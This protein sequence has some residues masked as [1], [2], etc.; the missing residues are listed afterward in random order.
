MNQIHPGEVFLDENG[1]VAQLHGIGIARIGDRWWAWG[2]DKHDGSS[3]RAVAC[4]S[5]DDLATW[6][7]EGD[8]LTAASDENGT[9]DLGAA[10][11]VERPKVLQHPDGRF[12]MLLHIDAMDYSDA[13]VGW[14]VADAPQGPYRY[15][16]SRRPLGNQSRDIG[17]YQEGADAYLLS[18]DRANGLHIYRLTDDYL[19]V[20]E[21]VATTLKPG[22]THGYE[23]PT[24]VHVDGLYYQF[25]SDLTGWSTN[26]NRY[27]TAES[28]AGP[29]SPWRLFAPEGSNTF[30]SQV[31]V[32][33]PVETEA[34]LAHVYIGD[35][36]RPD[37]LV[38]SPAVWLPLAVG[39][40]EAFMRWSDAWTLGDLSAVAG[41]PVSRGAAGR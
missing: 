36:W 18:E 22:A 10:R 25:G 32:V 38:N 13:K 16:G 34:G 5:S 41:A 31:S 15:L 4:Y 39:G 7:F 21:L 27:S 14:A 17:V 11:I 6:R 20:A 33:L 3:F 30:D 12:V 2:E 35:R 23:S 19:D 26:D 1:D 24:V 28:L 37:D 40:G 8:A 9:G 29:W